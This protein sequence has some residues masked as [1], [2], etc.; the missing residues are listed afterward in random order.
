M[1]LVFLILLAAGIATGQQVAD[2]DFDSTVT[3]PAYKTTHPRVVV[4]A[5]HNNFHTKDGLF[6]P[7][8]DLL[9]NDGYAVVANTAK[10]SKSSLHGI[11]VLVISNALGDL[12]DDNSHSTPAFTKAECDAVYDWISGGGSLLLIADHAP[13]GD[14]AAPMAERLGVSLGTGFVFDINP[15]A[16]EGRELATLVFS[17]RNRLLGN[18][19]ITRGRDD[20]ERLQKLVAFT[21]ESMTIPPGATGILRLSP[22]AEEVPTRA[23]LQ[24]VYA[25]SANIS[26]QRVAKTP[27]PIERAMAIAFNVGRG[28][29][30]ISGEAGMFTAQ[31]F[32][33]K[34]ENG[35]D[36]FVGKMGMNVSGNDDRQYV[37][38]VL[39]WLSGLLK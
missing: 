13:M 16:Y 27:L 9:R 24:Q 10:F 4:D 39:H 15:A 1:R 23:A 21:G 35:R 19:P 2:P 33:E 34:D 37:L 20:A 29:V 5:A 7:F 18:H 36:K 11:D 17:V 31:V 26:R 12:S 6:K 38:N 14:A 30:V 25:D 32:R 8:A 28:R 22:T 3:N